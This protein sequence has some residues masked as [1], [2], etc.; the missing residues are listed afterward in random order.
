VEVSRRR[1]AARARLSM[2]HWVAI[3]FHLE[4]ALSTASSLRW[5][6]RGPARVSESA[7]PAERAERA[8]E[9]SAPLPDGGSPKSRAAPQGHQASN[10]RR[11]D[12]SNTDSRG[13]GVSQDSS[14]RAISQQLADQNRMTPGR[15][16]VKLNRARPNDNMMAPTRVTSPKGQIRPFTLPPPHCSFALTNRHS[17]LILTN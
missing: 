9:A 8:L 12:S 10:R 1:R 6:S 13:R 3:F 4:F 15:D 14:F 7:A 11:P 2:S 5:K 16:I 17:M